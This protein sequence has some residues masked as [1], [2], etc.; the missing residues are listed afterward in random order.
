MVGIPSS[1]LTVEAMKHILFTKGTV[2]KLISIF[3][4][5][6]APSSA[7]WPPAGR[8]PEAAHRGTIRGEKKTWYYY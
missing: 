5:L 7:S 3:S 2:L 1:D 4:S 6:V 8:G